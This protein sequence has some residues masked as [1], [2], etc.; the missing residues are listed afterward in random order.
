M[1][2]QDNAGNKG[3]EEVTPNIRAGLRRA[4]DFMKTQKT[5]N[6][7]NKNK[8]CTAIAE[9]IVKLVERQDLVGMAASML[10]VLM[11]Q[12]EAMN[13]SMDR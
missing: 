11:R 4:E 7:S 1:Q 10:M 9:A 12:L 2:S 13:S 8:E 6:L 3:V 5:K